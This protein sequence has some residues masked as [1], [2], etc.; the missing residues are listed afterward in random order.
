MNSA[1]FS[2]E[3][4]SL[5]NGNA[6]VELDAKPKM[7]E[8]TSIID[9]YR[10][11]EVQSFFFG[12]PILCHW[13]SITLMGLL[14][15][16]FPS[17]NFRCIRIATC[18][19]Y[20]YAHIWWRSRSSLTHKGMRNGVCYAHIG[21]IEYFP[22]NFILSHK[23]D[24]YIGTAPPHSSGSVED[25]SCWCWQKLATRNLI[26]MTETIVLDECETVSL[27]I[28][29]QYEIGKWAWHEFMIIFW[30]VHSIE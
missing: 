8:Y 17:R 15:I 3:F 4:H 2:F 26:K 13:V 11:T 30:N 20:I 7:Y 5:P 18:V 29:Q 22:F 23:S 9:M 25:A 6:C 10:R 16:L 1:E 24:C 19:V 27:I 28:F 12:P 14:T 21:C